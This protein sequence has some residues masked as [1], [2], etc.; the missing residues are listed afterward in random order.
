M[1][2]LR[3]GEKTCRVLGAL[4][5]QC[6]WG[7]GPEQ[8]V[9]GEEAGGVTG[10]VYEPCRELGPRAV[11]AIKECKA[12]ECVCG[13]RTNIIHLKMV[14]RSLRALSLTFSWGSLHTSQ[15]FLWG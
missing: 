14:R 7:L 12:P 1:Q 4:T 8:G 15:S 5:C 3:V 6:G 11:G 9:P 13:R 2:R 10:P